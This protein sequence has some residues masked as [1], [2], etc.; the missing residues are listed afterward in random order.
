MEGETIDLIKFFFLYSNPGSLEW[1]SNEKIPVIFLKS[2]SGQFINFKVKILDKKIEV[3]KFEGT[4]CASPVAWLVFHTFCLW[5]LF[6]FFQRSSMAYKLAEKNYRQV[7]GKLK[8]A[9]GRF[10]E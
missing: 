6:L 7:I 2:N 10:S 4:D 8:N 9:T 5:L 3:N 1:E